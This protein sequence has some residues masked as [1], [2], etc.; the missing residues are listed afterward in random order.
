MKDLIHNTIETSLSVIRFPLLQK[1]AKTEITIPFYHIVAKQSNEFIS[2][3][4]K[5]LQI[6]LIDFLQLNFSST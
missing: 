5:L 3:L 4:N 6:L 2:N 1:I